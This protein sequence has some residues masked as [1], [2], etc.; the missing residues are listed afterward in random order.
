[1]KQIINVLKN[2]IFNQEQTLND[3]VK[4][5][6]IAQESY[7]GNR[8][9]EAFFTIWSDRVKELQK[10]ESNLRHLR[11]AYVTICNACEIEPLSNEEIIAE[12]SVKQAKKES[13]LKTKKQGELSNTGN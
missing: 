10:T 11:S 7:L 4:R 6:A 3:L 13:R 8:S 9:N 5:V 1:M 12:K 2:E